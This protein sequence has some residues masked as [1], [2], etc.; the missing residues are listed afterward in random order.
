MKITRYAV[1]N[2]LATSAV[3]IG[4]LVLG[5]YGLARLP[6]DFL[7]DITYPMIKVHIWWHGATPEEIDRNIADP[8]ER[9]MATVDNLDYLESSSIEGMY[10]LLVNFKYGVN[11]DTAYQDALAAMARVARRL[12]PRYRS[13]HCY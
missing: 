12:P 1:Y 11:I 3:L 7:P 8:I 10:T 6:V 5:I 4:L 13:A 9:Q 2:H